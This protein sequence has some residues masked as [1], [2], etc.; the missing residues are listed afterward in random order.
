MQLQHLKVLFLV[1]SCVKYR[2]RQKAV[3]DTWYPQLADR[4][5][6]RIIEGGHVGPAR[7]EGN[8]LLLPCPD[9]YWS[10]PTKVLTA[11]RY[12]QS[13][14]E[15]D[16]LVKCD[17]DMYLHV[18]RF[19]SLDTADADYIGVH[20]HD[21]PAGKRFAS[22]GL[23]LLSRRSVSQ[24]LEFSESHSEEFFSFGPDGGEGHEDV[25]IGHAL[26]RQGITLREDARINTSRFPTPYQSRTVV[27]CHWATPSRMRR[28][29]RSA[30]RPLRIN[31]AIGLVEH[32]V[33]RTR[34]TLAKAR[35]RF[36]PGLS[37]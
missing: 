2:D 20:I 14:F 1:M 29:H 12:A 23:Y 5:Q 9:G 37:L 3:L 17:D 11:L 25:S 35:Q 26:A 6:F 10:N 4:C 30:A 18:E 31:Q 27:S 16:Y 22:G 33:E 36:L 21:R 7:E 15:F 24:I 8:K 28:I 34:R 19:F 13:H 32:A